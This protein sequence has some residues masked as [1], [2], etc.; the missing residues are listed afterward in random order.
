MAVLNVTPD[1]FHDG[2][3]LT[4]LEGVRVAAQ[5]ALDAGAKVLD[6]GGESTRPGAEE[7]DVDEELRRVV[8]AIRVVAELGLPVSVDTRRAAVARA[9]L[10][11]GA[12]IV[13]DV[14]GLADPDMVSVVAGRNAGLVIGHLRGVPETMQAAITFSDLVSEI[15]GELSRSIEHAT[16]AGV[17]TEQIVVDPG[18]GF[19]KTAEQSAALVAASAV[20]QARLGVPVMIG[21]SRKSF[22]GA[23]VPS[24]PAQRLPG[25]LAAAVLAVRHG[26]A[27][28]R[29]HDVSETVQ[30]LAV[31]SAIEQ[32]FSDA[33]GEAP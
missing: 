23:V 27:V 9:A 10:E 25:S 31:A 5:R 33:V 1:S 6:V 14:S 19:G 11:A 2:G 4:D 24:T 20:L 13:N 32:A 28:V 30:A 21:A 29:V 15:A 18:V 16:A 12:A 17:S 3:R 26:A 22:I 8:P 7:V